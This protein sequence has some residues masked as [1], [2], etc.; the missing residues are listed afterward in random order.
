MCWN[1][2]LTLYDMYYCMYSRVFFFENHMKR[3]E[4]HHVNFI[5]KV[6]V[7]WALF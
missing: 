1:E 3:L 4:R 7:A 5:I 2:G 6:C